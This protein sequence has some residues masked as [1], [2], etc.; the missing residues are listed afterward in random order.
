MLVSRTVGGA[1]LR[2]VLIGAGLLQ[3]AIVFVALC[4]FP[5]GWAEICVGVCLCGGTLALATCY[6][7]SQSDL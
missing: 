6:P 3:L 1:I 7:R 5:Q 4:G 2:A